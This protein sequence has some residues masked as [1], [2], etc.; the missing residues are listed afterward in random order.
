VLNL[1]HTVGHA[2]EKL[3]GF[4]LRHGE[5]VSIGM[6]AAARIAAELDQAAPSLAGRIEAVLS[7]WGLPVQCPPFDADAIWEAMAHDKKRRGQSLRWVLPRAIGEV[8]ITEDVPPQVIK[9]VLCNLAHI[10]HP[11]VSNGCANLLAS[12]ASPRHRKHD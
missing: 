1:G 6:V 4:A 9:S 12:L 2:L 11:M 7:A 5:A 10:S 3:S 8:E